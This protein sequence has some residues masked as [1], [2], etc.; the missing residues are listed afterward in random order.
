MK[1]IKAYVHHHRAADV[2]EAIKGARAW[3]SQDGA[4][5]L[6]HIAVTPVQGTLPALDDAERHYS[7]ELGLEVVREFKLE[8]HCAD[9]HADEL[10]AAIVATARTGQRCAGWVYVTDLD[11][12]YPIR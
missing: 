10:V 8:L 2:I 12:A 3:T 4:E 5:P 6:H 9:E 7:I 1:S 11:G